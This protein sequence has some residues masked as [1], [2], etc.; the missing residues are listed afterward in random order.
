MLLENG[1]DI[2]DL[3]AAIRAGPTPADNDPLTGIGR[4]RPDCQPVAHAGHLFRDWAPRAA[5]A[6]PRR[7]YR[8]ATWPVS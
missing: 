8:P 1:Q 4:C 2:G 7:R 5:M 6:R 3:L